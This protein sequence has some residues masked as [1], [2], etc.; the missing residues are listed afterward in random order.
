MDNLIEHREAQGLDRRVVVRPSKSE[1]TGLILAKAS[2]ATPGQAIRESC[3]E[4]IGAANARAAFDCLS[5]ICFLHAACPFWHKPMPVTM[6]P[7]DYDGEPEIPRPKRRR[8][9][10]AL[11]RVYCRTCQPGDRTDCQGPDCAL[12]PYRP[13]PGP[14]HAPKRQRTAEQKVVATNG[15]AVAAQ[16]ARNALTEGQ[17][18]AKDGR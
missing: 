7:P 11:I 14:G 4:C 9:S 13:W 12:Y 10:R 15:L 8:P 6:R 2:V 3:L 18:A 5:R 16:N 17:F 1:L